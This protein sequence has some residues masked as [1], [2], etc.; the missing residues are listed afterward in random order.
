MNYLH[1]SELCNLRSSSNPWPEAGSSLCLVFPENLLYLL[2]VVIT[3]GSFTVNYKVI[4]MQYAL[5][6]QAHTLPFKYLRYP[7]SCAPCDLELYEKCWQ[8]NVDTFCLLMHCICIYCMCRVH[9]DLFN[10]I[11][12]LYRYE[13]NGSV[14]VR[15]ED[16][17][18][19][20]GLWLHP[21]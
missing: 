13:H 7:V 20:L 4:G 14:F 15:T 11:T 12:I 21:L 8:L 18:G 19:E 5:P 16:V 2:P 10:F 1:C 9:I 17:S 3:V 6:C